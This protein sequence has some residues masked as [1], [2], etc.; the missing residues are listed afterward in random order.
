M[1]KTKLRFEE[2]QQNIR[3]PE[4]NI[5]LVQEEDYDNH[6]TPNTSR[7]DE[8]S[9]TTKPDA[10]EA[11]SML[12]LTQKVNRDKLAALNRHLNVTDNPDLS[13]DQFRLMTA[14]MAFTTVINGFL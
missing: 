8:A 11:T 13:V 5:P 3:I 7:V 4:E 2:Q 6:G 10:I 12:R 14:L 9:F 1:K